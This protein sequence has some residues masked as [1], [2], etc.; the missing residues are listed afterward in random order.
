[1]HCFQR[2][3]FIY[4][5]LVFF[6]Q[7]EH[8]FKILFKEAENRMLTHWPQFSAKVKCEL[9]NIGVREENLGE[10]II[11]SYNFLQY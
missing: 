4:I 10:K 1:M 5:L 9:I 11:F 7:L 8:D 2:I 3:T 6:Q